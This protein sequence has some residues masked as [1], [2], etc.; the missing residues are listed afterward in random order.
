MEE[1]LDEIAQGKENWIKT[2]EGFYQPFEK[3][4]KE[5][6]Q[7]LSKE[8]LIEKTEKVCPK[9][10]SPLIIR[11][12]RFGKFYAC[13]GFPKCKYTEPLKKTTLGIHCPKCNKGEIVEKRSKRGKL[14]YSCN[15]WP[16]CDFALWDKPISETCPKC[17]SLLV[18]K[19]KNQIKC[20]NKDCDF[21]KNVKTNSKI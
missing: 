6:Y 17:G 10:K 3:N 15:R 4:L 11:W 13:S 18:E 9:C 5:K 20:S 2:L 8:D 12:G 21:V 14:F 7:K 19:G 1:D 16:D